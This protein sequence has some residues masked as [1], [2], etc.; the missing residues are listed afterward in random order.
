MKT[1]FS[2]QEIEKIALK[3]IELLGFSKDSSGRAIIKYGENIKIKVGNAEILIV[4]QLT[5]DS[6]NTYDLGRSALQWRDAYIKRYLTDGEHTALV[7]DLEAV[8]NY[9][10]DQGWIE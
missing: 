6:N 4:G 9:A 3:I 2:P 10:K 8:I 7:K 5:P 1:L